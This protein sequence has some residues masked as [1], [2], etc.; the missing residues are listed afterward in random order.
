MY[1]VSIQILTKIYNQWL[2]VVIITNCSNILTTISEN[3]YHIFWSYAPIV[4]FRGTLHT[5][6][7]PG[8]FTL[9]LS[10]SS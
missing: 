7:K 9:Y 6:K 5:V 4:F 2:K 3:C 1:V 10:N 8:D